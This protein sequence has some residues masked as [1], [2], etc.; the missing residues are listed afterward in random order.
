[1]EVANSITRSSAV[2]VTCTALKKKKTKKSMMRFHELFFL[3][4][5]HFAAPASLQ[6]VRSTDPFD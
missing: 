4:N 1:M 2:N 5:G 3:T 6:S